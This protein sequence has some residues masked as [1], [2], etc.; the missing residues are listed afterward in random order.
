MTLEAT[1]DIQRAVAELIEQGRITRSV[2]EYAH[3]NK[4]S[5]AD[6]IAARE[7]VR[8]SQARLELQG[9]PLRYKP[10]ITSE[11]GEPTPE[12]LAKGG[13]YLK[14]QAAGKGDGY[15]KRYVLR[16]VM[17][18]HADKFEMSHRTAFQTFCADADLHQ[19]IRVADLNSS[20]GGGAQRLGGLGNVPDTIRMR[21]GRY[22][23]VKSGLSG[24][25]RQTCDALVFHVLSKRDGTPFTAEEYGSL[26]FKHMK[27][28][29][30]LRGA[31]VMAFMHLVDRLVELYHHPLCPR[32][33]SFA[34]V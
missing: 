13:D 11:I 7:R 18:I 1:D 22:E 14:R 16:S 31:A 19:R 17:D 28:R 25:D 3:K 20:G 2:V 21:H 33:R 10:A 29:S 15:A 32:V 30:F 4:Y 12:R 24:L 26:I 23:W 9:A 5:D 6:I 27:D 34:D 8:L